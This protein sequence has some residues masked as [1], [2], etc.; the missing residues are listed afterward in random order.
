LINGI[1]TNFFIVKRKFLKQHT[2]E[3]F[4]IFVETFKKLIMKRFFALATVSVALISLSSCKK[5]YTCTC[6]FSGV[7]AGTPNVV[8]QINDAK[9]SD[10]KEAC[11]ELTTTYTPIGG[12][13]SID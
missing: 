6:T 9:K 8:A 12:S 11:D 2:I 1:K 4:T 7:G 5:D 13:C 3:E 10:A